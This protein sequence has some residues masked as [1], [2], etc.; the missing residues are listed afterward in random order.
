MHSSTYSWSRHWLEASGRLE[1]PLPKTEVSVFSALKGTRLFSYLVCS[2]RFWGPPNLLSYSYWSI[3]L[4]IKPDGR[5]ADYLV[6]SNTKVLTRATT[7]PLP[8]TFLVRGALL[9]KETIL[10]WSL[11]FTVW[12][13]C[14]SSHYLSFQPLNFQNVVNE[15]TTC[16]GTH[17]GCNQSPFLHRGC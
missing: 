16:T 1:A 15:S 14:N 17:H 5:E 4:G 2:S 12:R 9:R 3:F 8:N 13:H 7:S 10:A 6:P 11:P